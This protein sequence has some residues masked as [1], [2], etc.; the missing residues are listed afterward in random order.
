MDENEIN[1][2]YKILNKEHRSHKMEGHIP[3]EPLNNILEQ[4]KL[5][6][7]FEMNEMINEMEQENQDRKV[8][9]KLYTEINTPNGME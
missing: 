9:K 6:E 2:A 8:A 4:N 5:N 1:Q 3:N 7:S